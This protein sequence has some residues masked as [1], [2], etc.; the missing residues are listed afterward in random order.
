[1]CAVARYSFCLVN[2]TGML[3]LV[4][5]ASRFLFNIIHR[6]EG[7]KPLSHRERVMHNHPLPPT[8]GIF[9]SHVTQTDSTHVDDA[10]ICMY[11]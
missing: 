8:I 9:F 1:M 4:A 2:S 11:T 6:K 5:R 10:Y 3:L 7:K